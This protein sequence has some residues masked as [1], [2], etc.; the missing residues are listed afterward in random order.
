VEAG[1]TTVYDVDAAI[2][3]LRSSGLDIS[4]VL[5]Y[6]KLRAERAVAKAKDISGIGCSGRQFADSEIT[7]ANWVEPGETS[8]GGG[9]DRRHRRHGAQP[10]LV[11][12]YPLRRDALKQLWKEVCR[13]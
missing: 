1:T 7:L 9:D 13:P 5:V 8:G 3:R 6:C 2:S 10:K 4:L 11:F 12:L